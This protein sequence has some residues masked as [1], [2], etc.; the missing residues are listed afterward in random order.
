V[1]VVSHGQR[2]L[3]EKV[4]GESGAC[5]PLTRYGMGGKS[6]LLWGGRTWCRLNNE[7]A[8]VTGRSRLGVNTHYLGGKRTRAQ[9]GLMRRG[10]V[11]GIARTAGGWESGREGRGGA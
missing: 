1:T 5:H 8:G 3:A 7:G 11:I 4:R 10:L 6:H 2:H 9:L